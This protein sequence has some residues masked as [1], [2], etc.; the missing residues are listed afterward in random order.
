MK[1]EELKA[2]GLTDEQIDKIM[3]LNGQDIEKHKTA[4]ETVKTELEGVKAQL[5]EAGKA[6]EGFKAMN[7]DQVKA[8]ADDWKAKAEQAQKDADAR[9]QALQF[10]HALDGALTGAKAKNARAVRALLNT[11]GLK[12]QNDGSILG[13]KD[14]LEK[15]KAD[16]D[17]LFESET[18]TPTI[19]TGGTNQSV[20]GDPFMSAMRKGAGLAPE[21]GK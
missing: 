4:A 8:S 21:Q 3:G 7:I 14:Q 5:T 13:L 11:D 16:N 1:R 12:L 6:I 15:I 19:V 9:V 17:Y 2:M 20:L 18:P 10:D